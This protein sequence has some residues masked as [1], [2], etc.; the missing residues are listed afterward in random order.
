MSMSELEVLENIA[1][2]LA[3]IRAELGGIGLMLALML[4]FKDMGGK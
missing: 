1:S 2:C 4:F 3:G